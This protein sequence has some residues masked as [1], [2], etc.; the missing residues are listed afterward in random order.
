LG[1]F[2]P[3]LFVLELC[4]EVL[5]W[6]NFSKPKNSRFK[7]CLELSLAPDVFL[8]SLTVDHLVVK[9]ALFLPGDDL[10]AYL[11]LVVLV[12]LI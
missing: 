9:G 2:S 6:G 12:L 8:G 10:W 5:L 11:K 4:K 3:L 1:V 7:L